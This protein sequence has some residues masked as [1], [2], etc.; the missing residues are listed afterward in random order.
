MRNNERQRTIID[1][2]LEFPVDVCWEFISFVDSQVN[3][4]FVIDTTT[5]FVLLNVNVETVGD[6]GAFSIRSNQ[7]VIPSRYI[8]L[9]RPVERV[10]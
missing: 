7:F 1:T 9:E 8:V 6:I 10:S 4:E 3:A 2:H 5:Q